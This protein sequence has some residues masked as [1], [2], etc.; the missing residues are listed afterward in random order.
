MQAGRVI[1]IPVVIRRV[2]GLEVDRYARVL[3]VAVIRRVGGLE[4]SVD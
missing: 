4:A 3:A 1:S 2:G